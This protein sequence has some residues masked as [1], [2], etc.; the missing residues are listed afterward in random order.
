MC[1]CS[2]QT[3]F[4]FHQVGPVSEPARVRWARSACY[5]LMGSLAAMRGNFVS[6]AAFVVAAVTTRS[7][8]KKWRALG[9]LALCLESVSEGRVLGALG[10]VAAVRGMDEVSHKLLA[11]HYGLI[12]LDTD[13]AVDRTAA[14]AITFTFAP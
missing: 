11:L 7:P 10:Y 3:G 6:A 5:V 2:T 14:G 8:C 13:D 9:Y 12:A 4:Q 1:D